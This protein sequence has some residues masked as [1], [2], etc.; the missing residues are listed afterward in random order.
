MQAPFAD[1]PDADERDYDKDVDASE[2]YYRIDANTL[3]SYLPI[4]PQERLDALPYEQA[5][6]AL[7]RVADCLATA[8]SDA[9][10]AACAE[11]EGIIDDIKA[12][13]AKAEA[14]LVATAE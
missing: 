6:R 8:F 14:P 7:Q 4:E 12:E 10:D 2:S 11:A 1:Q 9:V 5:C 13:A 3:Y